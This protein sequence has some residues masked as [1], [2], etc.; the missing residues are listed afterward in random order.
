MNVITPNQIRAA[1]GLLNWHQKNLAEKCGLSTQT[2]TN[3]ENSSNVASLDTQ[4]KILFALKEAGVLPLGEA[5]VVFSNS[6]VKMHVGKSG[7]QNFMNDVYETVRLHSTNI[8]ISGVDEQK[9]RTTLGD[10]FTD[11]HIARMSQINN[12][13][14]RVITSSNQLNNLS[15]VQY[16]IMPEP[17]FQP[18][19]CYIYFNKIA[20]ITWNP[21]KIIVIEDSELASTYAKIFDYIWDKI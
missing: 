1:R 18:F 8:R 20:N 16:K 15:Y 2:I 11:I 17:Y 13:D 4:N 9:F 21:M 6:P 3:I 14:V 7:L 5:G 19:P 12:L 10:K